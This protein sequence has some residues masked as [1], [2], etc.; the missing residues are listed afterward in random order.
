MKTFFLKSKS[1]NSKWIVLLVCVVIAISSC[2]ENTILPPDLVPV[3]DNINTFQEDT[4]TVIAHTVY[5]DSLLTGGT[6]GSSNRSDDEN[7]SSAIGA[8][9]NDPTF[10]RSYGAAYVQIVQPQPSFSFSGTN[11]IIDSIFLGINYLRAFGDTTAPPM[12]TFF[13]Y[14]AENLAKDDPYY[15]FSKPTNLE[16]I[17]SEPINFNTLPTDSPLVNGVRLRPQLRIQFPISYADTLLAQSSAGAFAD[18]TS[19]LNWFGGLYILPDTNVGNTLGY[20][21]TDNTTLYVYYRYTESSQQDTAVATFAFNGEVCNRFNHVVRDYSGSTVSN[22]INTGSA[23]GDANIFIQGDPGVAGLIRF[24]HIGNFPN[25]IVNKAELIF[26][27]TSSDTATFNIPDELQ[28]V[29]VN[30][31]GEDEL[32]PDYTIF[33]TSDQAIGAAIQRV[34]ATRDWSNINGSQRIQYKCN[35]THTIQNAL[36]RQ[37]GNFALKISGA[38]GN[39]PANKRVV[40]GGSSNSISLEKPKLN[41]IF[42]KIQR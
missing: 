16:L 29:Y 11:Q 25:A 3:V 9:T 35:I 30:A 12:Q 14:R 18:Y 34:G 7:F 13:V 38:D 41:I 28:L 6:L 26:T 17:T 8:I 31:D 27:V 33:G 23:Q 32:L 15:E 37:D 1:I 36:T 39:Y 24:P 2:K 10:G 5:K 42:T 40:I 20:F 19:F 22:F 4:F 21:D